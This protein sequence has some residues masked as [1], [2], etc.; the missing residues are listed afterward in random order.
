MKQRF[1]TALGITAI[2]LPSFLYGGLPFQLVILFFVLTGLYEIYAVKKQDWPIWVYI[3]ML[4]ATVI[5]AQAN[6]QGL[7]ISFMILLFGL[8]ILTILFEWFTPLDV[9]YVFTMMMLLTSVLRAVLMTF[10]VYGRLTLIFVLWVT[11]LTDT[12]AYFG[13]YWFGKHK[14]NERI[15]P[16]KTI[17]GAIGGWLV[18]FVSG[19][20][21]GYFFV[22][23]LPLSFI[24][25]CSAVI[26][27]SSQVGDLA[28]SAI[29]RHFDIKDFGMIFPAHGGVIDR[30]DS[31][32]FSM[33]AFNVLLYLFPF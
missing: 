19:V 25:L 7:F 16:K 24:I 9:T 33:L 18:G 26:P 6:L 12:G 20:L 2:V 21:F 31:L 28:F 11:F 27:V 13:G 1:F 30:I 5:Y 32:V 14:L 22:D 3:L 17:E 23:R 15:S 29:K 4:I 8:F 10:N